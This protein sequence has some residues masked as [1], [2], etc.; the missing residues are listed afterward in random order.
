MMNEEKKYTVIELAELLQVPRTTINDWLSRHSQ[1]IESLPQGKRKVYT[2][3]SVNVLREILEM[4]NSGLSSFEIDEQLAKKHPV[5]L[6]EVS[7]EKIRTEH[8]PEKTDNA[9][10]SQDSQLIIRT[11][12]TEMGNMIRNA[13]I[14]MNRRMDELE[15]FNSK[16]VQKAS[17]WYLLS[18]CIFIVFIATGIV[19]AIKING[20]VE[21]KARLEKEKSQ[22]MNSL[23]KSQSEIADSKSDIEKLVQDKDKLNSEIEDQKK[24]FEKHLA[25]L[26]KEVQTAKDAEMLELRNNFAKERLELLKSLD[27]VKKDKGEMA[28]VAA[29]LQQQCYDQSAALK[30]FSE[31]NLNLEEFKKELEKRLEESREKKPEPVPPEAKPQDP[32]KNK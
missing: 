13:L 8:R 6:E 24:A 26:K 32:A 7:E 1:F 15:N 31:K 5:H 19:A 22:I 12:M 30:T 4:R 20:Y 29:K 9:A 28:V 18:F 17:R 25:D 21:E 3:A 16:T 14:D 27:D 23:D 10:S 2:E 11:S